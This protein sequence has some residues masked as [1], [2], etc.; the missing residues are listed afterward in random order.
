MRIM[1]K[2]IVP[3]QRG[4]SYAVAENIMQRFEDQKLPLSPVGT[5]N[6]SNNYSNQSFNTVRVCADCNTTKTPLWRSGPRG[7]KV[8]PRKTKNLNG[9]HVLNNFCCL[10]TTKF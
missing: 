6:S 8:N 10:V 1:R 3:D 4:T 7:P 5:D 9:F 2:M